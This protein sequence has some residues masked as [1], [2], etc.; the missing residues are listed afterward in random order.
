MTSE[1]DGMRLARTVR[2]NF[3]ASR[4]LQ[5]A[6]RYAA[7]ASC[8]GL[9]GGC[10]TLGPMPMTTAQTPL[11]S[12]RPGVE[13][14]AAV[15]PGYYLSD[16]VR[17]NETSGEP[18]G[19]VSAMFE[20]GEL[21]DLQGLSLGGRWVSGHDGDGYPEPMLRY[22][23]YL[24]AQERFA[25]SGVAFGTH[26]RGSANQQSYSATRLGLEATGDMLLTPRSHWLELHAGISAAATGLDAEGTYCLD[27]ERR[28]GTD[29][30]NASTPPID[31]T[32]GGVYPSGT[33]V[34]ALD[35]G[36]HLS[37]IFHGGRLGLLGS[38]GTR[39]VVEGGEQRSARWIKSAG[40]SLTLGLGG[41]E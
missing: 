38:V 37:D 18:P 24:D 25:V 32:A 8:L 16:S 40:L 35:F 41:A 2:M 28:F 10:A 7:L 15:V 12:P 22:R 29:C 1:T 31:A 26:A 30:D 5:C 19:Q 11:P 23:R 13:I 17:E 33:A 36:R 39:P 21:I 3:V 20:P 9:L 4:S 34:L 14:A 27:S 6:L